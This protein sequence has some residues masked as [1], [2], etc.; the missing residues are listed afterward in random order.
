MDWIQKKILVVDDEQNVQ[1]LLL[2][3][4]KKEGYTV[5][6]AG[7]GEQAIRKMEQTLF[8]LVLMDI[9]MPVLNGMDAFKI[10][11]EKYPEIPVIMMTAFASVDTA[12]EAMKLGAFNYISKPFNNSAIRVN[13]K[14]SLAI[15]HMTNE[16]QEL[17]QNAQTQFSIH[18][19]IGHS[20][21]MQE[22][23]KT[24]GKVSST[25]TT[26]L[27]QG[28]SGTGKELVAKAIHYNSDRKDRPLVD[29][30]CAALPGELLE[31]EMFGHEKGSFTGASSQKKGKFE[32]AHKGT[33]FL[34]EIGEMELKL[35][36][37]LLRVIQE[38]EFQRVGGLETH[39]TD[40]R[41]IAASN[42][43][44][45]EL[46]KKG[47][48]REDLYYRLNVV[49]VF[50]PP[51]RERKDDLPLLVDYFL[52]K[53]NQK[54]GKSFKCFSAEAMTL[55]NGYQWSGNVRELENAVERAVVMGSGDIIMPEDLPQ[56]LRIASENT[57]TIVSLDDRP[58]KEI[59]ME[60][61][62][63]VIHK[64]LT[65]TGWNKVRT[66]KKLEMSRKALLY[67]IKKYELSP[68]KP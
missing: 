43:P 6:T 63:K 60:V 50:I 41:I 16:L 32:F 68:E 38:K 46:V 54:A 2:E 55:L 1:R 24:I 35:Q 51:L 61:E 18:R 31:S 3:V 67:K 12:I 40:V 53:F 26:V 22:M 57:G 56:N 58:L 13:V 62:R 66:A 42:C 14:R 37:K 23:Y 44:M 47:L 28:E 21:K 65:E 5:Q 4:L 52:H 34:D 33:I 59:L 8:D 45:E 30:N 29:V 17:R 48:F 11:I 10:I 36:A 49:Q 27:I 39:K 19:M 9:Q 20:A 64:K 25:N 7:N 15:R